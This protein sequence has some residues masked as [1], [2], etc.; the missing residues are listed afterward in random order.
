[1]LERG[2]AA[3]PGLAGGA[4]KPK[5][6]VQTSVG[7]ARLVGPSSAPR[8]STPA[9]GE[10]RGPPTQT[11]P[12][13]PAQEAARRLTDGLQLLQRKTKRA[14]EPLGRCRPTPGSGSAGSPCSVTN[15]HFSERTSSVGLVRKSPAMRDAGQAAGLC[16]GQ[17]ARVPCIA[18][19]FR[20]VWPH[21]ST[22]PYLF[23]K[24]EING[25]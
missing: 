1:M 16:A 23:P 13:V 24:E 7:P 4:F 6:S 21:H 18:I 5:Q 14:K 9:V 19:L 2:R 12:A 10:R 8:L 3:R 15:L 22:F 11:P 17:R 20:A 25:L